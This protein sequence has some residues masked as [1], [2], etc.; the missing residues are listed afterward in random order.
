MLQFGGRVFDSPLLFRMGRTPRLLSHAGPHS[1]QYW[2]YLDVAYLG[3]PSPAG[4][5]RYGPTAVWRE[6]KNCDRSLTLREVLRRI[7]H[8][9]RVEFA[10]SC[11][12]FWHISA[13]PF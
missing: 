10:S 9:V 4:H 8:P 6:S 5:R 7:S 11:A 2:V 3:F 13:R 12:A 1:S